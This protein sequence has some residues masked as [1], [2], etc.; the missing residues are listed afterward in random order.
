LFC[1]V[2]L[3]LTTR[4]TRIVALNLIIS[5]ELPNIATPPAL[6]HQMHQGF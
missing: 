3:K 1:I 2:W 5:Y 6:A 4:P